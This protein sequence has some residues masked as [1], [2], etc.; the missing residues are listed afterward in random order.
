MKT[1]ITLLVIATAVVTLSFTYVA[2]KDN[3]P[4][5]VDTTKTTHSEVVGGLV[6]EAN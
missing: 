5:N 1:K 4:K 6:S 2:T 3:A